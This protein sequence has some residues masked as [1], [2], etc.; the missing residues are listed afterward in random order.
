MKFVI[1]LSIVA[2]A[3]AG[4]SAE[5]PAQ[6]PAGSMLG[7]G[8]LTPGPMPDSIVL[9]PA[10][11]APGSAAEARDVEAAKAALPLR[12]SARWALATTDADLFSPK[13]T[14]PLSC[15]AGVDISPQTTPKLERLLRKTTADLGLSTAAIKKAHQRPRPFMVNGEPT[16]TPDWEPMLRKDGSYP[17]GHSAIGYGWGLILAELVPD[18]AAKIVARGRAFGDSR[19]ICNV[20]WL[21]DIEEGRIAAAATVARL[22]SDPAFQKDLKAARAELKKAKAQPSNCD[23][24]AQTLN[25]VP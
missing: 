16:C 13:S 10:P 1:A 2:V 6:R 19:R 14:I 7:K 25:A 3:A 17:S 8:Y 21:S 18:R 5:Q 24:E 4:A 23:A 11:P 15:A 9:S 12:G 20:H 22:H